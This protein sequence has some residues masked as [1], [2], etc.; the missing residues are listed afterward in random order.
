MKKIALIAAVA[1]TVAAPAFAQSAASVAA[2]QHF[3]MFED[4]VLERTNVNGV[5]QSVSPDGALGTAFSVLNSSQDT[6][7]DLRGVNGA[8]LVS[9]QPAYGADIFD[10]LR[11]AALEDE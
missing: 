11:A 9:G 1:V 7:S 3:N 10:R 8:T 2:I 4:S 5:G 6:V